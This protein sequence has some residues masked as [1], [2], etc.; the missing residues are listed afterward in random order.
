MENV[1][2][3]AFLERVFWEST[4]LNRVS[5]S[6]LESFFLERVALGRVF[7][8]MVSLERWDE[9]PVDEKGG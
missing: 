2:G 4:F 5:E 9:E 1:L 6:V 8:G 7:D 3:R